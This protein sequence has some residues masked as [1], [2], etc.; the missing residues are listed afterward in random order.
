MNSICGCPNRCLSPLNQC[1]CWINY[2]RFQIYMQKINLDGQ[3]GSSFMEGRKFVEQERGDKIML[4]KNE[5]RLLVAFKNPYLHLSLQKSPRHRNK[6]IQFWL[7]GCETC[8]ATPG[9]C[10]NDPE[11]SLMFCVAILEFF[12]SFEQEAMHFR[13]HEPQ[14]LYGQVQEHQVA[15][16]DR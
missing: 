8:A 14:R 3:L 13:L 15:S 16:H 11:L 5:N 1:Y 9:P 12:T 6:H 7:H 4:R 2:S 10:Q